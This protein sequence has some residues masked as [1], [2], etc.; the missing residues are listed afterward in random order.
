[1][2]QISKRD[3]KVKMVG[4][5]CLSITNL[6]INIIQLLGKNKDWFNQ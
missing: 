3:V 2:I 6:Y 5:C 1:M 4:H